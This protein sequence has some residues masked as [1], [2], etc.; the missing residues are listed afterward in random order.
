MTPTEALEERD[1]WLTVRGM[2][3][4]SCAA[5]LEGRLN[6][7]EGVDASVNFATERVRVRTSLP[8][9]TLLREVQAAGFVGQA[10]AVAAPGDR[11]DRTEVDRRVKSLGRRLVVAGLLFM[12]LC[13]ISIG[14]SVAPAVRF[15]G[16]QWILVILALPVV[17]WCAWP[18]YI[19]ALRQARHHLATMDTLAAIGILAATCWSFFAMFWLD[20]S[21]TARSLSDVLV[22]HAGGSLYLDVAA[23]VTTFLLAGRYIEARS[24]RR[25]GDSLRSLA[26]VGAKDV[27]ILDRDGT[28]QLRPISDLMV[29][30]RFVVRP[31]ET[32]ASDGTVETGRAVLDHS[33]M[34]GESTPIEVGTGDSVIGGTVA[35]GGRLVVCAE[36]VGADTQL[37]R[38][39]ELVRRAQSEKSAAQRLAD[40]IAGIFVP[41]VLAIAVATLAGWLLGGAST[42]SALNAALSV[43]IIA[44]PCALG[45]ATPMALLVASDRGARSGIFFKGYEAVEF[46]GR[47]DTVLFDKTG[48]ITAGRMSVV[49]VLTAPGTGEGDVL[50]TAAALERGSEHPVGRA[51]VAAA[52]G[53][54]DEVEDFCAVVGS[55]VGGTVGGRR[56]WVGSFRDA[57]AT[58]AMGSALRSGCSRWLSDART[59]VVVCV[60]GRAVGAIGLA[61]VVRTEAR[62]AVARLQQLGLRCLLLT[63][64]SEQSAR[65]VADRVGLDGVLWGVSPPDKAATVVALQRDGHRVAV[66]GDGVNDGP[67]LAQADLGLALGSGTDVARNSADIL[68]LRD[69]LAAVPTAV[70]LARRTHLTIRRNLAWAFGYNMVAIPTAACGLLNPLI[71]AAAMALSSGFVVWNSSRLRHVSDD[72]LFSGWVGQDR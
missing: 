56:V 55:G 58:H 36:S 5:R 68:V 54:L 52:G 30:D 50:R 22:H 27:S 38:M 10:V 28:E 39:L 57:V 8:T 35:M 69:D 71:A 11:E 42:E 47:V 67:A 40:R 46:S 2:T 70:T 48:T 19:A 1:V 63:G 9:A 66:V 33:S 24:R 23:G 31:G 64:D 60:D 18:F 14:F 61:D 49:G 32:V 29:G 6:A 4:G 53:E 72:A 17:T 59:V 65:S 16:W 3:C 51:I 43:L 62:Q 37:S 44:C 7:L 21:R 20:T 13:D 25:A 12:P 45:L 26:A 41:T 15:P 34:T